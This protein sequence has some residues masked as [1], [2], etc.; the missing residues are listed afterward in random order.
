[1]AGGGRPDDR[2]GKGRTTSSGNTPTAH[3][4]EYRTPCTRGLFSYLLPLSTY[5]KLK[6]QFQSCTGNVPNN[7]GL[8]STL[9]PSS[10]IC[11]VGLTSSF[12]GVLSIILVTN[13][14][15]V[16]YMLQEGFLSEVLDMIETHWVVFETLGSDQQASKW[17][18]VDITGAYYLEWRV[19]THRSNRVKALECAA[20]LSE[21]YAIS[22]QN[23]SAFE[24]P[25]FVMALSYIATAD[26]SSALE[27][28]QKSNDTW[29]MKIDVPWGTNRENLPLPP[30]MKAQE[31]WVHLLLDDMDAAKPLLE[32]ALEDIE[33]GPTTQSELV[34]IPTVE[35]YV[36]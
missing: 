9:W 17:K 21:Y 16:R 3:V 36:I 25:D 7:Q 4:Q 22:S 35:L 28:F 29:R 1:M 27:W 30:K 12:L 8:Y 23:I 19:H 13:I 5:P 20:E 10:R 34:D 15:Y 2:F 24:E 26:Y 33:S 6:R 11:A 32:S 31:A 18:D 14:Y